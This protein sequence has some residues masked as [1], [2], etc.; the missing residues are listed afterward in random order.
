M[1]LNTNLVCS[2]TQTISWGFGAAQRCNQGTI[3]Y[4]RLEQR[5]ILSLFFITIYGI[6]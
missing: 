4:Q 1:E 6:M 5:I 3:Q 2:A